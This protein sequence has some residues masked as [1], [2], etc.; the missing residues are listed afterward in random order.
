M[1]IVRGEKPEERGAVEDLLRRVYRREDEARLLAE[2]RRSPDFVPEMSVVADL[3]GTLAGYALFMK[4]GVAA[5]SGSYPSA[6][7][8]LLAVPPEHKR[9]GVAERLIRHSVERGRGLGLR[10]LFV[11]GE[12]GYFTR[13]GFKKASD[14]GLEPDFDTAGGGLLVMPLQN[15]LPG[16]INGK[17]RYSKGIQPG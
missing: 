11:I 5:E 6:A 3:E 13:F 12:S 17:V 2:L 10:F 4:A 16:R 9:S 15:D 1:A 7:L 14:F 8:V